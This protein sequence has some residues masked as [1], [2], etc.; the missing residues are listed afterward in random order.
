MENTCKISIRP[1]FPAPCSPFVSVPHCRCQ[2]DW[3]SA[4]RCAK[5]LCRLGHSQPGI[6]SGYTLN[7]HMKSVGMFYP[8]ASDL[9]SAIPTDW[10]VCC[11]SDMQHN[12]CHC[13]A[14][15]STACCSCLLEVHPA[16]HACNADHEEVQTSMNGS[17]HDMPMIPAGLTGQIINVPAFSIAKLCLVQLQQTKLQIACATPGIPLQCLLPMSSLAQGTCCGC[18]FT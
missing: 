17:F 15:T 10:A 13:L 3:H 11:S 1:D 16:V 6:Q 5:Q 4:A 8:G 12:V 7:T 14:Q 9:Y 2:Y 18:S